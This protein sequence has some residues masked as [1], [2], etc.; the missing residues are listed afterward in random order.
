MFFTFG[1]IHHRPWLAGL[2]SRWQP[3]AGGVF[4]PAGHPG[5]F[6]AF[7]LAARQFCADCSGNREHS[8]TSLGA[9]EYPPLQ[10]D[11][12]HAHSG[13]LS[14]AVGSAFFS[15][16]HS[17]AALFGFWHP[18][19]GNSRS[20]GTQSGTVAKIS[21]GDSHSYHEMEYDG[22]SRFEPITFFFIQTS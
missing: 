11:S 5:A 20:A 14:L 17:H 18:L 6:L 21:P 7:R 12:G 1:E 15:S 9:S 19:P 4:I 10:S 22:L 8:G 3:G 2:L 13:S 16:A